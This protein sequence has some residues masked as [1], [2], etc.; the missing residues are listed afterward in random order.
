[1]DTRILSLMQQA[2]VP[3]LSLALIKGG[4]LSYVKGYGLSNTL[5]KEQVNVHTVFEGASLGKPLFVYLVLKLVD[6]GVIELDTPLIQYIG[7]GLSQ[8]KLTIVSRLTVRMILSH[9][10]GLPNTKADHSELA[11]AFTPGEKFSYS[12]EAILLLQQV[13]E[14]ITQTKLESLMQRQVFSPLHMVSSSYVYQVKYDSLKAFSHNELLEV[15]GRKKPV[16]AY[17][18]S[19]LHTTAQDYASFLVALL[20]GKGLRKKTYKEMIKSQ[21]QVDNS[22][23]TCLTASPP[24]KLSSRLS[25]GLGWGIEQEKNHLW[26]WHWGDNVTY[27]GFA[28]ANPISKDAMVYFTNSSNGLSIAEELVTLTLGHSTHTIEWLGYQP[29]NTPLKKRLQDIVRQSEEAMEKIHQKDELSQFSSKEL[30][31][32]GQ[33]LFNRRLYG[34]AIIIFSLSLATDSTSFEAHVGIGEAY[35]KSQQKIKALKYL[36]KALALSLGNSK[37]EKKINLLE[38]PQG[39]IDAP[40][41]QSYVG[42]YQSTIGVLSITQDGDALFVELEGNPK[43]EL[44]P[45]TTELFFSADALVQL[46]F[47]KKEGVYLLEIMA[48]SHKFIALKIGNP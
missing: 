21:V 42:N 26:L 23:V 9:T 15:V 18:S 13:I 10:T 19:S 48:G 1:M 3:G 34:K 22:C 4:K 17:A 7:E 28:I 11:F 2:D 40:L 5:T 25:W 8:E 31:W 14:H 44:L 20:E 43:E 27:K 39:M 16:E 12:G 32:L 47:L 30:D 41:A 29:Y 38:K 46:H 33:Q 37:L 35:L 24:A 36:K 45:E 6:Q